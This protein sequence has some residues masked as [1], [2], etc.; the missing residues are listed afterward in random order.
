MTIYP[1][2]LCRWHGRWDSPSEFYFT[3]LYGK[4][5]HLLAW[6]WCIWNEYD[7]WLY[8]GIHG[9]RIL[10]LEIGQAPHWLWKLLPIIR[11]FIHRQESHSR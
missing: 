6:V 3:N 10:G 2:I 5:N 11:Y 8:N 7:D 4:Q 1:R 9:F